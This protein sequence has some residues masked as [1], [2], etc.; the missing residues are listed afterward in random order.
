MRPLF[1][2]GFTDKMCVSVHTHTHTHT[3]CQEQRLLCGGCDA[4]IQRKRFCEYGLRSR[5]RTDILMWRKCIFNCD[6]NRDTYIEHASWG[7]GGE[8]SSYWPD[9]TLVIC[10][11]NETFNFL[12]VYY[13]FLHLSSPHLAWIYRYTRETIPLPSKV[14][15][16]IHH[17]RAGWDARHPAIYIYI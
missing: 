4:V 13:V 9:C 2:Y 3:P 17:P 16:H 14:S 1:E 8:G 7:K 11:F 5:I 10:I 15:F 6:H 12:T